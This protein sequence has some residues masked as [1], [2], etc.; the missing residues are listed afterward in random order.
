VGWSWLGRI[1]HADAVARMEAA[2]E[3]VL[4]GEPDAEQLWLC[5]HPPVVTLGKSA[6]RGHVVAGAEVL[7]AH[8]VTLSGASRGGDVTYHGPGQLMVYPVMR[9]RGG[10]V[11]F[12]SA[13]AAGLAETAARLG[14]DG[15]AWQREPAGLW[16][17]GAKMAACGLH[18]RRGVAIHGWAFDVATPPEMWRLIVP[19]GLGTPVVSLDA[20]RAAL[21]LPPAPSVEE[22]AA[23]AG[24]VIA[25]HLRS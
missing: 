20:A 7:A 24:P 22:V 23:L 25:K 13:V 6:D 21:G 17:R 15:A 19:C 8:G 11:A 14:V 9:A 18:L 12:L 10:V 5:E 16:W 4:A 1:E 2:R 3:R